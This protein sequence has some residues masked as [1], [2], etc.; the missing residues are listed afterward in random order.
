MTR[1]ITATW[2]KM[3]ETA[4]ESRFCW[5]WR[6]MISLRCLRSKPSVTERSSPT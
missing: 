4:A 3:S 5:N 2:A 6:S 1:E